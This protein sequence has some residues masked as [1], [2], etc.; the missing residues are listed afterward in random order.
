MEGHRIKRKVMEYFSKKISNS[1][2]TKNKQDVVKQ[3]VKEQAM[4]TIS[5]NINDKISDVVAKNVA[6]IGK[7]SKIYDKI[8]EKVRKNVKDALIDYAEQKTE[9]A[10]MLSV[11]NLKKQ[12]EK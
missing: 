10:I 12:S 9:E 1:K 7:S 3:E 11:E 6:A 8:K 4:T 2:I 5:Q